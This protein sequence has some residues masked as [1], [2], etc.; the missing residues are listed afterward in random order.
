MA[1]QSGILSNFPQGFAG[2]ITLRGLP[3]LQ[4]NP[5]QVFYLYNGSNL[6]KGE[7]GGSDNNRGTFQRPFSTL[8]GALLDVNPGKGD[9]IIVKPGHAETIS[10]ATALNVSMSDVAIIGM[11]GGTS[12]PSFTLDTGTTSTIT[13]TGNNV[14]FQNCQF[15]GNFAA[16]AALFTHAQASVTG[17]ISGTTMTVTAVGSGTLYPGNTITGTGI[18]AGTVIISQL[19][20]TTGGVGTY[21]VSASQTVS[22]VTIT[23]LTRY[24]SLDQ[25]EIRDLSSS[26]NFTTTLALSTTDNASDG[27]SFT[28][29]NL[30]SL[31][32]TGANNLFTLAGTQ[33][34][35]NVSDNYLQYLTTN[36]GAVMPFSAGKV[37]TNFKLMRNWFNLKNAAATATGYLITTNSSTSTGIIDGNVDHCLSNTTYAS[38]L[39]VTASSGL[40]FGQN[41]HS[42]TADKSPGTVLPAADS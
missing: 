30:I 29:N 26:L 39:Q 40:V 9:I 7:V 19:S 27:F 21:M 6:G 14:S 18:T 3:I 35:W 22:S 20:G 25:C 23:T 1:Q 34:R 36:A 33:D 28:R 17:T 15:L 11:G 10:S 41:W 12:R 37:A 4:S 8:A 13:I 24:F 16:V 32:T 42:R 5:G 31:P 2:G 38:S